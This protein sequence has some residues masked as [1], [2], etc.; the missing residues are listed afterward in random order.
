MLWTIEAQPSESATNFDHCDDAYSLSIR[1][2]TM[3]NHIRFVFYHNIKDNERNLC[4]DLLTT[5]TWM[6]TRSTMQMSDLCASDF[7][8]KYFCTLNMQKQW[9]KNVWEKSNEAYSLPIRVQTTLNHNWFVFYHNF[10]VKESVFFR[11][12]GRARAEN[13]ITWHIDVCS[14]VCTLIDHGKLA[15][16][17]ARLV[18]IVVKKQIECALA[19]SVLLSTTST[20][21]HSGQN[22]VDSRGAAE[23][24]RNKFWP[25][26][27]RVLVVDKS[28]DHAKPHS[29]CFLPQYQR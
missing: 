7:L 20:R 18:A 24:V 22:V 19:W 4:Q 28:A 1:V 12:R 13:G 15:N 17:I 16:Q 11:A 23:W 9:G 2:Q 10:N 6:C 25:L 14:P 5:R 29:I 21:H 27:W 8:F 26:W 3:L